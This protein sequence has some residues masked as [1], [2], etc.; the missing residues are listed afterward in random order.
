MPDDTI[1]H[2]EIQMDDSIISVVNAS[3]KYPPVSL[4]I[5]MYVAIVDKLFKSAMEAECEEV[6]SPKIMKLCRTDG[7]PLRTLLEICRR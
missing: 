4:V 2:A 6:Y 3:E 5:H 7:A 1:R